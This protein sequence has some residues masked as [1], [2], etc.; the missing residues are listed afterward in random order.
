MND[1]LAGI[2]VFVEAVNS[3][4][5]SAAAARLNLSRS[6]VGK[7]VA[8]LE[9]RLGVLLFHRTTR[10][11]S[12]TEDG[13]LFYERC[14]RALEEIR[15]GKS[16][17][18]SGRRSVS[19]RLRV[20]MP[21]LFGRSCVAPVLAN[22][23]QQHPELALDLDFNDH[24]VNVQEDDFDLVIRNG[25][26][27]SSTSLLARRIASYSMTVW[28]APSY[29]E[30][31]GAPRAVDE[32]AGHDVIAY[33]RSGRIYGWRFPMND[34]HQR[35]IQPTSR[36]CFND[37]DAIADA[38]VAGMGLAWLPFWLIRDRVLSGTL[39]QVLGDHTGHVVDIYALW[40]KMPRIPLR[41]R[42]AID[43]LVE[44]LPKVMT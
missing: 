19:G 7:T 39:A 24:L 25:P 12:L 1:D 15:A 28:A 21:V 22:L 3:G 43:T 16:M 38:A 23:A 29:I 20:S 6:A 41:I 35:V 18:D 31:R 2:A 33:G 42:V 27:E 37:L 8:K 4:G 11:Q 13:Q 17:I 9:A 40:P 32:I 30:T 14:S 10:S 36:L 26:L 5:F 34:A 44:R